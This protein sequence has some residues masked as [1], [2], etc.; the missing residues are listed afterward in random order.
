MKKVVV[1]L[2]L[3]V[4]GALFPVSV[5]ATGGVSVSTVALTVEVGSTRTFTITAAN[6]IGDVAIVSS[7]V[8]V[9]TVST[10]EWG[11]G[12][13]DEGQTKSGVIT[14]TGVSEGSTTVVLTLDAATFDGE[15][16]AGQTRIVTVNV[17]ARP[18]ENPVETNN[19]G[20]SENSG[21]QSSN[22]ASGG[23]ENVSDDVSVSGAD[24]G[25]GQSEQGS[26]N[27]E[28]ENGD[29]KDGNVANTSVKQGNNRSSKD[30]NQRTDSSKSSNGWVVW[31]VVAVVGILGAGGVFYFVRKRNRH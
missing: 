27:D 29:V 25:N 22:A 30:N 5:L 23:G 4:V 18:E 7:N 24:N 9:A 6:V 2:V 1:S 3:A 20:Q 26:N 21:G 17:V 28:V 16:L 15:D 31:M 13:V 12:M 8:G 19:V 10:G 14:V 11:T